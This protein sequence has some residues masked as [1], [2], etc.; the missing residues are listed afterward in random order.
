[1]PGTLPR[2]ALHAKPEA[3]LPWAAKAMQASKRMAGGEQVGVFFPCGKYVPKS[4][5]KIE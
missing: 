5:G 1:M 4:R 3:P 2:L